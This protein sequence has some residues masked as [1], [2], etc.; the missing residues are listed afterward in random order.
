MQNYENN[1]WL[2]NDKETINCQAVFMITCNII[3]KIF[4]WGK[5][6]ILTTINK[7]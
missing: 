3:K 1:L 4:D 5:T 2:R 6:I 7:Y